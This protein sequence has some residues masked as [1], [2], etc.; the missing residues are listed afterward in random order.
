MWVSLNNFAGVINSTGELFDL[1]VDNN[2]AHAHLMP[3]ALISRQDFIK[4]DGTLVM[5]TTDLLTQ[6]ISILVNRDEN[7]NAKGSLLLD[8]GISVSE[9]TANAFEHYNILHQAQSIQF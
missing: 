1:P 9:F 2:L 5:T 4:A 3:G 7:G 6:P 8:E